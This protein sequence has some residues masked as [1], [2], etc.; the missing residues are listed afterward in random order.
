[1]YAIVLGLAQTHYSPQ[2]TWTYYTL[3][4]ATSGKSCRAA[5]AARDLRPSFLHGG[6]ISSFQPRSSCHEV[7]TLPSVGNHVTAQHD[8]LPQG[9]S[10]ADS[11][12]R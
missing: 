4:Y 6:S 10:H 8:V 11:S 9:L 7:L 1:L 5:P 3:T 2:E 12:I